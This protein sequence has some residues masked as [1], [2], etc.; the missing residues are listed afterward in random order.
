MVNESGTPTSLY[1]QT[2]SSVESGTPDANRIFWGDTT[3]VGSLSLSSYI[4]IVIN[5]TTYWIPVYL[6]DSSSATC[7]SNLVGTYTGVGVFSSCGYVAIKQND[8][9]TKW[10]AIYNKN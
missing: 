2:F 6:G 4:S 9:E 1:L 5:S 10:L 7:S 8:T 3:T